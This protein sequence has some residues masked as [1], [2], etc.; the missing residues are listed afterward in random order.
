[1]P[2]YSRNSVNCW[3]F[4]LIR[5]LDDEHAIEHEHFLFS[6]SAFAEDLGHIHECYDPVS[7]GQ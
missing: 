5:L 1:M 7:E 3:H 6:Y 4:I 2:I